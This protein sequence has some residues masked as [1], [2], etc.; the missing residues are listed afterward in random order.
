MAMCGK[1]VGGRLPCEELMNLFWWI[2]F[3]SPNTRLTLGIKWK[4]DAELQLHIPVLI[5]QTSKTN[6]SNKWQ[7]PLTCLWRGCKGCRPGPG[8]FACLSAAPPRPCGQWPQWHLWGWRSLWW[9]W[10]AGPE[11]RREKK[12]EKGRNGWILR[13]EEQN[14]L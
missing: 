4:I 8:D 12:E 1:N 11:L 3:Y 7:S 6:H 9:L 14:G 2:I 5:H 10:S 13:R